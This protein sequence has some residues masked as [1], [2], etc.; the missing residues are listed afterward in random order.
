MRTRLTLPF[1]ALLLCLLLP[2][3]AGLALPGEEDEPDE[4]G[5]EEGGPD[6]PPPTT[7]LFAS[8]EASVPFQEVPDSLPSLSAQSCNACHGPVVEQWRE[9]GHGQAWHSPLYQEALEGAGEP[10]YCLRGHLP[11]QNQRAELVR[12]YD[13]NALSKPRLDPNPRFD[14]TLRA[15][16]VTCAACHVRDGV[17]YGPRTLRPDESPHPVYHHPDLVQPVTCAACHQLA[18]PGTEEQPLYNTYREWEESPWAVAGVGCSDCHMPLTVGP[19]SGSRFAAHR[20][21]DVRGSDDDAMLARAFTVQL[22]PVPPELQRGTELP[23][24]VTVMNTG[25]GHH[26]PTGNPHAWIEVRIHADGVEGMEAEPASWPLRR[27][28]DLEGEHE[29]GEDTRIPAG[30]V[31]TFDYL[32]TPGKKTTAPA[33]LR[34]EVELWYHRLP[35]ELLEPYGKTP[36]EVGRRFHVQEIVIPLR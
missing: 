21:H 34:V 30:G 6:T 26:V 36:E 23:I 8:G 20:S 15:E 33:D 14:P 2:V 35:P 4:S 31:A 32:V 7:V 22:S 16:G 1:G 25:A 5:S 17:V 3:H 18:W 10:T 28:V 12:G 13:E 24:Q 11:L 27:Q 29:A 19:V 9:S